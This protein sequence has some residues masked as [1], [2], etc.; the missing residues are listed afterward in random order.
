[1]KRVFRIAVLSIFIL[2]LTA[3]A[4]PAQAAEHGC[5]REQDYRHARY[6]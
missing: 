3:V 5:Y 4:I 6:E 2:A 1:M